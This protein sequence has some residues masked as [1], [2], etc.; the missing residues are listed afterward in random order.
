MLSDSFILNAEEYSV[1]IVYTILSFSYFSFS[2]SNHYSTEYL[3]ECTL[4]NMCQAS[5][6]EI[7]RSEDEGL[8]GTQTL[9]FIE[10][11]SRSVMSDSLR[12]HR[13]YSHE[14]L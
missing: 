14:I 4:V 5:L 9:N 10:S 12:L 3:C 6:G 11:E 13:L 2:P 1:D 8:H 7:S